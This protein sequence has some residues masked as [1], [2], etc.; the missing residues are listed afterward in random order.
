MPLSGR[1]FAENDINDC[2]GFCHA[3]RPQLTA[4]EPAFGR[5]DDPNAIGFQL[6]YIPLHRGLFPHLAVHGWRQKNRAF[7]AQICSGQQVIGMP[8][9]GAGKKVRGC[10]RDTEY[11]GTLG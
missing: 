5:G 3:P 10:G 8:V 2:L 6:P 1:Q 7:E 11:L 9:C 4:A